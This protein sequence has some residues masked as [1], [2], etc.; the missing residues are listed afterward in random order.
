[1]NAIADMENKLFASISFSF[2]GNAAIQ[3][4]E[5]T[6]CIEITLIMG[7]FYSKQLDN[8]LS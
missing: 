1:M 4:E 8:S 6:T 3:S 7:E 2:G 5:D